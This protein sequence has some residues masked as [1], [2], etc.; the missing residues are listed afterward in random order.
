[1]ASINI[2]DNVKMILH[3]L[4]DNNYSAYIVGGCVRDSLMGKPPHDWDICT[5]CKP[6]QIKE[7]F[8]EYKTIDTGIKHGTVSVVI[9]NEVYEIT[10]YRIDGQYEDN[11]HP[12]EITFADNIEEDLSRRDFTINAMAYN[13]IVGLVDPFN[14][15]D[16]LDNGIIRCVG[17]PAERFNEDALRIMRALRFAATLSF[18][19]DINTMD[20]ILR[21]RKLLKN[22]S[23]ERINSELMKTIEKGTTIYELLICLEVVIP[24]YLNDSLY[25]LCQTLGKF[26]T[27]KYVTLAYIHR[28]ILEHN[29]PLLIADPTSLMKKLKFSNHDISRVMNLLDWLD[30]YLTIIDNYINGIDLLEPKV[31]AKLILKYNDKEMLKDLIDL[32]DIYNKG[33]GERIEISSSY[34]WAIGESIEEADK[35]CHKISDLAIN[36]N[37][38]ISVGYKG[39]KIGEILKLVLDEIISGNLS[40]NRTDIMVYIDHL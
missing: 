16:D 15:R 36:G 31:Q 40:N 9:D 11:R 28:I 33:I 10:T 12:T 6:N 21:Y 19:I 38:L 22:I 14:G 1:V 17:N 34:A 2:P 39:K 37:D 29:C 30:R 35:E 18:T 7:I 13:D 26:E 24:E 23:I 8:S 4:Y 32:I 5:S 3:K 25:E 20:A 27:R